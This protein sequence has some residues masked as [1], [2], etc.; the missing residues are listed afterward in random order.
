MNASSGKRWRMPISVR[1]PSGASTKYSVVS[2][3]T[4]SETDKGRP[5]PELSVN[6]IVADPVSATPSQA[7]HGFGH[8]AGIS[9][10]FGGSATEGLL[11]ATWKTTGS[12]GTFQKPSESTRRSGTDAPKP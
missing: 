6:V 7:G 2:G 8:R 5:R 4:L 3:R 9:T 1:E 11:D 10:R 12:R